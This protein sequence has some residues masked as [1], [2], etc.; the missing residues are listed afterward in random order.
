MEKIDLPT[1][2]YA[3]ETT[4]SDSSIE[5]HTHG[6]SITTLESSVVLTKKWDS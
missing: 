6:S 2:E 1:E 4:Q 3:S 5:A